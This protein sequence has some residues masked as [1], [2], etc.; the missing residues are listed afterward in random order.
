MTTEPRTRPLIT[1]DF[2][3]VICSPPFGLNL[4]ITADFLDPLAP[5]PTASVPPRGIGEFADYLRFNFRRPM[6]DAAESLRALA[7]LREIVVLT[8][9]RTS[10]HDW[11]ARY[12]LDQYIEEIIVN[13]TDLKSPHFKL[14]MVEA[15]R[16][17][18]HVDDDG[19]TAQLLAQANTAGTR[20]FLCDW[21]RN[22]APGY[23]PGVTRT[24]GLSGVVEALRG[25]S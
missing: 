24:S 9:R 17:S 10:P 11:L 4:G 25:E 12:D 20:V 8:G 5:P 23:A 13:D 3:G 6:H 15:L 2:D 22:R 19:R 18:E 14:R 16:P 1:L 7:E 21:P